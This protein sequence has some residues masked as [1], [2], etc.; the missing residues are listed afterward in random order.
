MSQNNVI[1]LDVVGAL[2]SGH[3][4]KLKSRLLREKGRTLSFEFLPVTALA[5]LRDIAKKT[6]SKIV[7]MD[8][9]NKYSR[10][11]I[12]SVFR[13]NR[14]NTRDY[15]HEDFFEQHGYKN[16]SKRIKEFIRNNKV[17]NYCIITMNDDNIDNDLLE[18]LI[19]VT[20]CDGLEH[21]NLIEAIKIFNK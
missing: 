16:K 3:L 13:L 2:K 19:L 10:E 20:Y 12:T 15:F 4:L 5:I 1:F 21:R 11:K 7:I 18:N 8:W 14:F 17:N 9:C 6:N